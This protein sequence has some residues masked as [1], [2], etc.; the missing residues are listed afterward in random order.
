MLCQ[1]HA[2][3]NMKKEIKRERHAWWKEAIFYQIYPL[4]FYDSNGDG[5]GDLPGIIQK[6]P[7]LKELGVTALWLSPIYKSPMVDNGYDVSDY[8]SIDPTFGTM[9]DFVTFINRAHALGM[10]VIIDLVVNHTSD[11]HPWFLESRKSRTNDKS[12]FYIW[13]DAVDGHEPNNW[14]SDIGGSAWTWD[15]TRQQYYLHLFSQHQPDLNWR[16]PRVKEEIFAM[17]RRWLERGIDGFRA[18]MGN[19]YIKA[20]GFP[21]APR[22][23]GDTRRYIH[24]EGLVA[25]Q[26]GIHE[27]WH[28]IHREVLEPY[29]AIV[30]GELY[31][32]TPEE[33]LHYVGYDRKEMELLYQYHIMDARGRWPE[34]TE[35]VRTWAEAFAHKA[36]NTITF[37]NHDSP[38]SVSVYG[39]AMHYHDASAK[40]I[41]TF[42]LTAPGTPFFLQGEEI[43]MNNMTVSCADEL[44]DIKMRSIYE[45]RIASGE[46]QGAVLADLSQWNRDNARTPMQWSDAEYAGFSSHTPWLH[47]NPQ[48]THINVATQQKDKHSIWHYVRRLIMIRKYTPALVYGDFM[49]LFPDNY[50]MYGFARSDKDE[51][52]VV[53]FNFASWDNYIAV[54]DVLR[55]Q[56]AQLLL[57]N[58]LSPRPITDNTLFFQPWE[59]R[60]YSV[61]H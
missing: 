7:Y 30:F 28:E 34:V 32:L 14:A 10:R 40:L 47:V 11:Q 61:S 15:E 22:A 42:L 39:D 43:G 24:P 46:D 48:Y 8:D 18:D 54:P 29:N 27:L 9:D 56:R 26:P 51:T 6:L 41:M 60:V 23:P 25:N 38:R 50:I 1:M 33:G 37:S 21:D 49:P 45:Q 17:M 19:F 44:T 53:L 59:T 4:S 5:K 13:H 55:T 12:D 57:C 58:V 52:I 2:S 3:K 20:E 16:N 31:F 35:A 36:W